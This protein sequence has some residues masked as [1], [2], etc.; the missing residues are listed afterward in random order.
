M[1]PYL[2]LYGQFNSEGDKICEEL[3]QPVWSDPRK[4]TNINSVR[5]FYQISLLLS[6][7]NA[8]SVLLVTEAPFVNLLFVALQMQ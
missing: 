1:R 7:Q 6:H 5:H 2:S 8:S 4:E 3:F